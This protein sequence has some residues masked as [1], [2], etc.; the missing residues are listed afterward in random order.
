MTTDAHPWPGD[1][2]ADLR[3]LAAARIEEAE[4]LCDE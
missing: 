1:M 3:S 4:G 2:V